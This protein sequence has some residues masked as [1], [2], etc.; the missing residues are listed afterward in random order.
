MSLT[1][2]GVQISCFRLFSCASRASRKRKRIK[3]VKDSRLWKRIPTEEAA[4]FFPG[5]AFP[6]A[7]AIDPFEGH[8]SRL[9]IEGPH[10]PHVAADAEVVVVSSE[11][12]L[13]HWPPLGQFRNVADRLQPQIGRSQLGSQFLGA[14]LPSKLKGA[15]PRFI[16]VMRKTKKVKGLYLATSLLGFLPCLSSELYNA[17]FLLRN[18]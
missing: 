3:I 18:F 16:A 6:L 17:R 9:L 4:K 10:L 5:K 8:P 12:R 13:E 1:E 11:F 2:P 7:S 14:C 15:L